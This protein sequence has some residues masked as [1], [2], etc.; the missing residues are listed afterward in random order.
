MALKPVILR[1]NRSPHF[2]I[3]E[4]E[5]ECKIVIVLGIIVSLFFIVMG[6][7]KNL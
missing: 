1:E 6:V 3:M 7:I 4:K 2:I 5:T